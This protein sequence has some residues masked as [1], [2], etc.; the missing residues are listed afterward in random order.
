MTK[1]QW[2]MFLGVAVIGVFGLLL[3]N[4]NS[5]KEREKKIRIEKE[6]ELTARMEELI[7][8]ESMIAEMTKQK[9]ELAEAFDTEVKNLKATIE[10]TEEI[11]KNQEGRLATASEENQTLK[12]AVE[13]KDKKVTELGKRIEKLEVD[14]ADLLTKINKLETEK[15]TGEEDGQEAGSGR[16][17]NLPDMASVN[18]GTIVMQKTSGLAVEVKHINREY[19]FIVINAGTKDNLKKGAVLNIVRAKKLVGKAVVE[20]TRPDISVAILL[21]EWTKG[22]VKIGDLI[23][24]L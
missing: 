1:K 15:K 7:K 21:P 5:V 3:F 17:Q 14:K 4:V 20:K 18:L 22:E 13:E 11:V 8:K 2:M 23:T 16:G 10:E 24:K 19:S 12:R 6:T 9:N